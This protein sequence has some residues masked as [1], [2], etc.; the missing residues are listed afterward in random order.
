MDIIKTFQNYQVRMATNHDSKPLGQLLESIH[1]EGA[2]PLIEERGENFFDLLRMHLGEVITFIIEKG[3]EV[4]GCVSFVI[5]KGWFGGQL[6]DVAYA[7]DLRVK[8][9]H[10]KKIKLTPIFHHFI[11]VIKHLYQVEI[12]HC[13]V[14]STN[15]KGINATKFN[16]SEVMSRYSMMSIQFVGKVRPSAH[17]VER[18]TENDLEEISEYLQRHS[19]QKVFGLQQ[20]ADT[21]KKR[22]DLWPGFSINDFYIIRDDNQKIIATAAPWN[23]CELRKTRLL[24]YHGHM[25]ILKAIY[26]L[27]AKLRNFEPLPKA[28]ECFNYTTL[29]HV[30]VENEDPNLLSSLLKA[31]YHDLRQDRLHMMSTMLVEGSPLIKA[32]RSFRYRK[33]DFELRVFKHTDSS[34]SNK[35][36]I[37][38]QPGFEMALH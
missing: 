21:L 35:D 14:I 29:T 25:R 13:A 37:T 19:K 6:M 26:N 16:G 23:N 30:E 4:V 15:K 36:F 24:A 31:I 22:I 17:R 28:G 12:F 9:G 7:C 20:D 3:E 2:M 33:T 32:F 1:S 18:A 11:N 34:F 27:E 5:R 10:R 38:D 8:A